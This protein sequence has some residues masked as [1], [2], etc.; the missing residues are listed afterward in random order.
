VRTVVLNFVATAHQVASEF[1]DFHYSSL[2][3][4]SV[5]SWLHKAKSRQEFI[6]VMPKEE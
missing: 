1:T 6:D 5:N 2:V 4:T 3:I